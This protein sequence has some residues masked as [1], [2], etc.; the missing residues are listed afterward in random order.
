MEILKSAT[1]HIARAYELDADLGTLEVGKIGDVVVLDA[2]PFDSA[3]N[4]RQIHAVIKDGRVVDLEGLPVS[5]IISSIEVPAG[6][7]DPGGAGS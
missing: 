2:N 5:P 3:R 1:S 6:K 7:T 4:Y